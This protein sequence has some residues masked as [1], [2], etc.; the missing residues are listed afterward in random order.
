MSSSFLIE[1][2]EQLLFGHTNSC[3]LD[4]PTCLYQL[5]CRLEADGIQW[6]DMIRHGGLTLFRYQIQGDLD[7]LLD[8]L[9][10]T[11]LQDQKDLPLPVFRTRA[12]TTFFNQLLACFARQ[13][14][15]Q[16]LDVGNDTD[17]S[18]LNLILSK[19][20]EPGPFQYQSPRFW[21]E[22]ARQWILRRRPLPKEL[23]PLPHPSSLD[24]KRT[25]RLYD[26]TCKARGEYVDPLSMYLVP[27]SEYVNAVHFQSETLL[28][29]FVQAKPHH[30]LSQAVERLVL[31]AL[32][33]FLNGQYPSCLKHKDEKLDI[34]LQNVTVVDGSIPE[35]S[36]T[37]SPPPKVVNVFQRLLAVSQLDDLWQ[38]STFGVDTSFVETDVMLLTEKLHM[39]ER[40]NAML[41][42]HVECQ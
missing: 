1:W 9:D 26:V 2:F 21:G 20:D 32:D 40:Q 39:A 5:I 30:A 24:M 14:D 42:K 18:T 35:A 11:F 33:Q 7:V 31:R 6:K 34:F 15:I 3:I 23:A 38:T 41:L 10:Q 4:P 16:S 29:T 17:K 22:L 36:I 13:K 25:A 8:Y 28:E 19:P 12:I 27:A 37:L